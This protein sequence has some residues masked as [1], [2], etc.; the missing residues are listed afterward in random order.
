MDKKQKCVHIKIPV[1]DAE[2]QRHANL[3]NALITNG[4]VNYYSNLTRLAVATTNAGSFYRET[5]EKCDGIHIT[6]EN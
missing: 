3:L 6:T 1:Y 4:E 2:H 5:C